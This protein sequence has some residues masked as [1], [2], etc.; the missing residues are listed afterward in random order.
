MI[1]SRIILLYRAL[2]VQV[3]TSLKQQNQINDNSQLFRPNKISLSNKIQPL[4]PL[5]SFI[6]IIITLILII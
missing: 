3:F 2:K 6:T 4:V 5:M 1:M